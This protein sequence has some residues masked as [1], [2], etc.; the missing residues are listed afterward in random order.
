[1][2]HWPTLLSPKVEICNNGMKA[3]S[4]ITHLLIF[5]VFSAIGYALRYAQS[6]DTDQQRLFYSTWPQNKTG[7]V[8]RYQATVDIRCYGHK[9]HPCIR[10]EIKSEIE[11]C[12]HKV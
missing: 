12:L 5:T 7:V 9:F 8:H 6:L 1:M 10:F 4:Q 2:A 11:T 3:Q